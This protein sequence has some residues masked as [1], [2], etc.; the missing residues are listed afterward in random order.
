MDVKCV[1][2]NSFLFEEVYIEQPP[3]FKDEKLPHHVFKLTK[4]LYGLK[5]APR[6]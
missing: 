1:F 5:Q 2:L 6:A 4:V 3:D